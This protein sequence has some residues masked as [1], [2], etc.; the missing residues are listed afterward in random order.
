MVA[1][2]RRTQHRVCGRPYESQFAASLSEQVELEGM[3]Y[4]GTCKSRRSCML[5][6][7]I[8]SILSVSSCF[9]KFKR[10]TVYE[11]IRDGP[12]LSVEHRKAHETSP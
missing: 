9:P 3:M 4:S 11:V 8:H 12:Y 7:M 6:D 5:A 2:S 1:T 10:S